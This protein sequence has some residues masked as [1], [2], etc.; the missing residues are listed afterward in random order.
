MRKPPGWTE[1]TGLKQ[2]S[3][4]EFAKIKDAWRRFETELMDAGGG[5]CAGLPVHQ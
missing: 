3:K 5:S 1:S 4:V 2:R